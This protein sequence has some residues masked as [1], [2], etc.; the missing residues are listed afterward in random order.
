M[1]SQAI[2]DGT[3]PN[4]VNAFLVKTPDGSILIDTGFGRLLTGNLA[5]VGVAPDS[6]RTL[7][8]T[9]AHGDHIGGMLKADGQ[10]AFP[11]AKLIT[12]AVE[13]R[14]WVDE[15]KQASAVKAFAAYADR[16]ELIQPEELDRQRP[17]GIFFIDAPGHTPGH[18]ACLLRSQG[19]QLLIWGDLT[20]AMAIQM[21]YP[22]VSVTYDTDPV[23]AAKTRLQILRFVAQHHIPV[24]GMHVPYPG[25]GYVK[26]VK[27]NSFRFEPLR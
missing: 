26:E 5:A 21:P 17:D 27:E 22:E 23:Q 18:I 1:I 3:Y 14:Y 25:M 2:P 15:K 24:A 12:S 6:V 7:I 11:Q 9:H 19:E 13:K 4:A 20:H 10:A 8:I 16:A